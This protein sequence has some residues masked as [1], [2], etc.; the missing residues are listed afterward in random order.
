MFPRRKCT[1][2]QAVVVA[3]EFSLT[4]DRGRL[5][6]AS[7][8]H[9]LDTIAYSPTESIRHY[10]KSDKAQYVGFTTR[11]MRFPVVGSPKPRRVYATSR[12]RVEEDCRS[13]IQRLLDVDPSLSDVQCPRAWISSR[14]CQD[15]WEAH[16]AGECSLAPMADKR[17]YACVSGILS[18]ENGTKISRL[19]LDAS[20]SEARSPLLFEEIHGLVRVSRPA[21]TPQAHHA[22][23]RGKGRTASRSAASH[24]WE[25]GTFRKSGLALRAARYLCVYKPRCAP[26]L[27]D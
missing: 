21:N 23:R 27:Q 1:E 9:H 4:G 25:M 6:L 8:S 12:T 5:K 7:D 11:S 26:L 18:R 10:G 19:L 16:Q 20:T 17:E 22:C 3:W 24:P 14:D 15:L 2:L 13:A